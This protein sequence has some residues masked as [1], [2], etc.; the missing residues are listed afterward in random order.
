M[1]EKVF[2]SVE[3]PQYKAN[4]HCHTT[5][6]DGHNTP[7][8]MKEYYKARGYQ[9]MA[10]TDHEFLVDHTDLADEDFLCINGYEYAFAEGGVTGLTDLAKYRK[11]R[12]MEFNLYA[13][14]PKNTTQVCFNPEWVIHGEMWRIPEIKAYE[15]DLPRDYTGECMQNLIDKAREHGFLVNLNHPNYSYE[16]TDFFGDFRGLMS[17]E[18]INQGSY[19]KYSEFNGQMYDRMLKLGHRIGILASDDNHRASIDGDE[20]DPR[21]WGCTMIQPETFTYEGVIEALEK[22]NYYASQAPVIDSLVMEDGAVKIKSKNA[23][24]FVMLTEFR[25]SKAVSAPLH[26]TI[27]EAE[28]PVPEGERYLRFEVFD[29]YG[30]RAATRAYFR[31]EWE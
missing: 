31:D 7:E 9:I 3:K 29:A 11:A 18:I 15:R 20:L 28:F 22:G 6:S 19:Y 24:C 4:L 16:D 26:E 2:I 27:D 10:M 25:N 21:P 13:K 17:M 5:I 12:T 23:K 8:E 30:R 1:T 14:D